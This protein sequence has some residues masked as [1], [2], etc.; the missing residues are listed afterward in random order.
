MHGSRPWVG[1]VPAG[2]SCK[3]NHARWLGQLLRCKGGELGLP[4]PRTR[5]WGSLGCSLTVPCCFSRYA[6]NAINVFNMM[7]CDCF[8]RHNCAWVTIV[9][10]SDD[11]GTWEL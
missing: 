9:H 1:R 4:G 3:P 11:L 10:G 2:Y 8:L 5:A 6:P 7:I